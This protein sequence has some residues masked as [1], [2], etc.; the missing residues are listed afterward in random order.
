MYEDFEICEENGPQDWGPF[1]SNDVNEQD[2]ED[3]A[4]ENRMLRE[5]E[6]RCFEEQKGKG[7][8]AHAYNHDYDNIVIIQLR[9]KGKTLREIA[10]L[11]DCSPSTIRNR[12][13]ILGMN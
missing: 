13:K 9:E 8:L 10:E 5:L 12:L 7:K 3:E 4:A 11:L 6:R 2:W 1:D